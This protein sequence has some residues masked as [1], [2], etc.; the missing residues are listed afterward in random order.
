MILFCQFYH[1]LHQVV[2]T[3][4][5]FIAGVA[6]AHLAITSRDRSFQVE[7]RLDRSIE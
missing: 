1:D 6:C 3:G 4:A 2:I 5:F 7:V